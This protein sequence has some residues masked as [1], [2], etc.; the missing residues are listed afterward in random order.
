MRKF[1]FW[2][3]SKLPCRIISEDERP[4]LERDY[5]ANF[6]GLVFY[7]HRFVGSD[8]DRGLHDH[9]WPWAVSFILAG[10]YLEH[11]RSGVKP[12][13][14]FN[15]LLADSFHR[16]VLADNENVYTLFIH[17]DKK[18]KTWGFWRT[19]TE[20]AE[21]DYSAYWTKYVYKYE[22]TLSFNRWWLS[23]PKGA[24]VSERYRTP[25]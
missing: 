24:N 2:L 7:I 14:W 21:G 12:V 16:V 11:N 3:T 10:R 4:Y 17:R 23:A 15:F 20:D 25:A 6:G 19:E 9:P 1:L 8:P 18:A 22:E 13:N 5:L